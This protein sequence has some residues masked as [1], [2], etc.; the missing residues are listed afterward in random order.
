MDENKNNDVVIDS[1]YSYIQSFIIFLKEIVE[2][3]TG[4]FEKLGSLG[5]KDAQGE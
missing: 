2:I 4:L 1:E 5:K 3:I